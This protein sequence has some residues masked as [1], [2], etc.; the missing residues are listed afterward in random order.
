M[1]Q[2]EDTKDDWHNNVLGTKDDQDETI[3]LHSGGELS[4]K[5][6]TENTRDTQEQRN[7]YC[8]TLKQ[9]FYNFDWGIGGAITRHFM[10]VLS[11]YV[12]GQVVLL[13]G[14]DAS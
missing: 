14:G 11:C 9:V 7:N 4:P 5:L 3:K 1:G 6:F 13:E 12:K 10:K 2:I 8:P